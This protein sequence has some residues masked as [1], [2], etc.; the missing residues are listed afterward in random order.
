MSEDVVVLI[1]SHVSHGRRH[2][3][4]HCHRTTRQNIYAT[5]KVDLNASKITIRARIINRLNGKY[6]VIK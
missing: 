1:V 3:L 6:V 5:G 2:P 4:L